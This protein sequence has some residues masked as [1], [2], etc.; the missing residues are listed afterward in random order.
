MRRSSLRR[1]FS[2]SL[3]APDSLAPA[4]GRPAT[5]AC[6]GD[7]RFAVGVSL[8][9]LVL[10]NVPF[11]SQTVGAMW[12]PTASSVLFLASLFA[13]ALTLQSLL[14]LMMPTRWLMRTAA[15]ALIIVGAI[16]SYFCSTYGAIMDRDMMRNVI[17]T[18]P[19]EAGS[20]LS[21]RLI[22][23][24]LILGVLPAVLVWRIRL[25]ATRPRARLC[26]RAA[27]AAGASV[28]CAAGMAA[29]AADYAVFFREHKEIRYTLLPAAPVTSA[30]GL[31]T[32][33]ERAHHAGPLLNPAGQS[34]RTAASRQRPLV[35]FLVVGETARAANFSLGGYRRQTN[36][37]L[38]RIA[39]LVYFDRVSSCATATATSLPCMFSPFP[40]T[41]FDVDEAHRYA[42]LL[43]AIK[44]AGID[45]E[46]HDNNSGCKGVCARV[47]TVSYAGRADPAHCRGAYCYDSVML[48][49]LRERL[50]HVSA[51]TL[52]VF[53]QIGSHGPAYFE[54]YPTQAQRFTPV[55]ASNELGRCTRQ[56][57]VNAYDNT[58]VATDAFL[59][60]QIELLRQVSDRYDSVLL[61]VSDHGESLGEQN[62]YLHGMPYAIA[63]RA[64]KEIPMLLWTSAGFRR[65]NAMT[66]ECMREHRSDALSHD[67]VYHTVL[68]AFETVNGVYDPG[69]DILARCRTAAGTART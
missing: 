8:L 26:G 35:M 14:L 56:Q 3:P 64:Q 60:A 23:Q 6:L 65:R 40:R 57:I 52:F 46:W 51:D 7:V 37:G 49:D 13:L 58:I 32:R 69:L 34:V 27:F 31:L 66:L 16:A 20:L 43:D 22:L 50:A 9:W 28:V 54:R 17:E 29:A 1:L 63:P 36:P 25:P 5:I 21:A 39:D 41:A 2:T 12:H 59:A 45:V 11:W 67:N 33:R 48:S 42:N 30:I 68:G 19:A 18:D 15:S 61:Y 62:L 4:E 55:C 53:H 10:Y 47:Q 44:D 24:A 38:E